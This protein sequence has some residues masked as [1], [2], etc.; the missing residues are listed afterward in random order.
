[1]ALR[2]SPYLLSLVD[3]SNRET[4]AQDAEL[5]GVEQLVDAGGEWAARPRGGASAPFPPHP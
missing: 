3:W 1:M 4:I 2:I 5:Q